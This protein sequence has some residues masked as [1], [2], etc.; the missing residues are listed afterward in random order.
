MW[1]TGWLSFRNKFLRPT[2][3]MFHP[4][5][6][7]LTVSRGMKSS[8][9]I[10]FDLWWRGP[11]WLSHC[12]SS[13]PNQ[14]INPSITPP[15]KRKRQLTG[16]HLVEKRAVIECDR[17]SNFNRLQRTLVFVLLFLDTFSGSSPI[18]GTVQQSE[19]VKTR[20][21]LVTLHQKQFFDEDL[22]NMAAHTRTSQYHGRLLSLSP[23]STK[24][25]LSLELAVDSDRAHTTLM[26][27]IQQS[28]RENPNLPQFS[29]EK[30]M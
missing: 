27:P 2:G 18:Q 14:P 10:S 6:T 19:L 20:S 26:Q 21:K 23:S 3:S 4:I 5:K 12:D 13:W 22:K 25:S 8:D 1:V 15:E 9:L 7:P 28:S 30:L 29:S 16:L 17:C 11:S 24:S